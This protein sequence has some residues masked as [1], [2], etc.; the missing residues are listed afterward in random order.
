MQKIRGS[1]NGS[2]NGRKR[3]LILETNFQ[4]IKKKEIDKV[5]PPTTSLSVEKIS[6][7]RNLN[8]NDTRLISLK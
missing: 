7:T 5:D 2:R 3:L 4:H 8:R 1:I 6:K